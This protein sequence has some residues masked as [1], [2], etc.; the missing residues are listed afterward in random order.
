[1][2][3]DYLY[4]YFVTTESTIVPL[5]I[6]DPV[7]LDA[8]NLPS[9]HMNNPDRILV[10]EFNGVSL[11]IKPDDI[12][13]CRDFLNGHISKKWVKQ[14]Y[15]TNFIIKKFGNG[16]LDDIMKY[17]L[18]TE[19]NYLVVAEL[20]IFEEDGYYV[21]IFNMSQNDISYERITKQY[22]EDA[23]IKLCQTDKIK[24]KYRLILCATSDKPPQTVSEKLQMIALQRLILNVHKLQAS[25][26]KHLEM[27]E[28]L[29]L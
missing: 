21:D 16:Y 4:S 27:R 18:L 23:I 1:M 13:C 3:M 25:D 17:K 5:E 11:N 15:D 10:R 28:C 14:T 6:N 26:I 8:L 20:N 7:R 19:H 29:C 2:K 9:H 22:E 12:T 24:L